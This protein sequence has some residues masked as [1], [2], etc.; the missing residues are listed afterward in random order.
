MYARKKTALLTSLFLTAAL[1]LTQ[2]AMANG[3]S[4]GGTRIVYP[5]GSKQTSLSVRNTSDS[6]HY[7]VQTWVENEAGNKSSDFV[8]TPPLYTSGPRDENILRIM[9][10]GKPLP[11]DRETLY[12]F[13]AKSIPSVDKEKMQN[14]N[15]LILAAVTR[16]KM[17]VRPSGLTPTPVKA[18]E[19]LKFTRAGNKVKIENPT[20]YYL[21]LVQ[22]KAGNTPLQGVMVAP[23]STELLDLPAGS[24]QTLTFSTM[25]DYGVP[26]EGSTVTLK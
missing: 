23:R 10:A 26:V 22:V 20:P 11:K 25:N 17:F 18:P 7:L 6:S 5:E 13:N 4:L 14:S 2:A 9:Y 16:I 15:M 1:F 12:Y 8:V 19:M 21:T 24:G 3:I